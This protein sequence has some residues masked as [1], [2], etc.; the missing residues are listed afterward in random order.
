MRAAIIQYLDERL[1]EA[2]ARER[3]LAQAIT[4]AENLPDD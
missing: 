4:G 2:R 1:R 3:G